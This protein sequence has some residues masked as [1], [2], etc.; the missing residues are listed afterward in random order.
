M[1]NFLVKS[2][3]VKNQCNKSVWVKNLWV[4]KNMG[5]KSVQEKILG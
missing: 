2:V 4:K 3:W 5:E 1:K